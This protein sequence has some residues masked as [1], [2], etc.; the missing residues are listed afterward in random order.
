MGSQ[1]PRS[2][3]PSASIGFC[4]FL[5]F[6]SLLG[7][8]LLEVWDFGVTSPSSG[9]CQYVSLRWKVTVGTLAGTDNFS[10]RSQG[11]LEGP[12]CGLGTQPWAVLS[13]KVLH[14]LIVD[15]LSPKPDPALP[16]NAGL[17]WSWRR[18]LWQQPPQIPHWLCFVAEVRIHSTGTFG[19][20]E[21]FEAFCNSSCYPQGT[22]WRKSPLCT[23]S[24]MCSS[25]R[26]GISLLNK[27]Y[28]KPKSIEFSILNL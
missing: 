3:G 17:V 6:Q 10:L 22:L 24:G 28:H 11:R 13:P 20:E 16:A 25:P 4:G 23:I 2:A 9:S 1:C 12:G 5:C 21:W 26:S 7:V 18:A 15:L 8:R 27:R 19:E 14:G